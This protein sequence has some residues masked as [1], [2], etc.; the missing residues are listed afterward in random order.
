M[1]GAAASPHAE[2]AGAASPA[3]LRG[4]VHQH[5]ERPHATRDTLYEEEPLDSARFVSPHTA[6]TVAQTVADCTAL[7][8]T[9]PRTLLSLRRGRRS[10]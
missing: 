3:V 7:G 1:S 6:H 2:R 5:G 10:T 8:P 4:A 9:S